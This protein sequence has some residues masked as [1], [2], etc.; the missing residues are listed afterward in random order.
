M[1]TCI[2]WW[3]LFLAVQY[4]YSKTLP[5][6]SLTCAVQYMYSWLYIYS[7]YMY[8]T[9]P[10]YITCVLYIYNKTLPTYIALC[11]KSLCCWPPVM[12]FTNPKRRHLTVFFCLP[13]L[14]NFRVCVCDI[15]RNFIF[16][17][18]RELIFSEDWHRCALAC[19]KRKKKEGVSDF[20]CDC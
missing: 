14:F 17:G 11:C 18:Q 3:L 2:H 15:S 9:L 10:T 12:A 13:C 1:C 16:V 19:K 20:Q 5:A 7:D 8:F 4:M 6:Y